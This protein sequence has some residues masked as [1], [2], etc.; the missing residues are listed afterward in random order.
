MEPT[1]VTDAASNVA[2]AQAADAEMATLPEADHGS[3]KKT[4]GSKRSRTANAAVPPTPTAKKSVTIKKRAALSYKVYVITHLPP[5]DAG[6]FHRTAVATAVD[7]E[8]V[9]LMVVDEYPDADMDLVDIMEIDTK[10]RHFYDMSMNMKN[11]PPLTHGSDSDPSY[12]LFIACDYNTTFLLPTVALIVA[13]DQND[14]RQ[15]LVDE[16]NKFDI[17]LD[18]DFSLK[19]LDVGRTNTFYTLSPGTLQL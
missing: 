4:S 14:A 5:P 7:K 16:N 8:A 12:P 3:K 13:K 19:E 9:G 1:T 15:L 2:E 17:E 6:G 18:P 11:W 10:T